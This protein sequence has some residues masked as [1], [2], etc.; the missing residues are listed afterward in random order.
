MKIKG[1]YVPPWRYPPT[2][3]FE[4]RIDGEE[5]PVDDIY[6]RLH[7][8]IT[9][10]LKDYT[11]SWPSGAGRVRVQILGLDEDISEDSRN[12]TFEVVKAE[13]DGGED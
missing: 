13:E 8:A 7:L 1:R 12:I 2:V 9:K 4:A 10:L 11:V 5:I 3:V 6:D